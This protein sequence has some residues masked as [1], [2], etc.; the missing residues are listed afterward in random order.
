MEKLKIKEAVI[1]EGKYDKNKVSQI[2][3]TVII[4][5]DGFSFFN[6]IDK[7]NFIKKI[8]EE[9]GII[10]LTDS[11]SAGFLIR[12]K[13]KSIISE[14]KIKNAYIPQIEG[15]EKRKSSASK[16]GLLGVEGMDV[17]IILNALKCATEAQNDNLRDL[18]A[19]DLY[20]LGL[21]GKPGSKARRAQFLKDFN[22]PSF[23][24]NNDLLKY[25][26][27]NSEVKQC[28]FKNLERC[29]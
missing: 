10:I 24:N 6:S 17:S 2:V 26:N 18:T 16:E 25:I 28:L 5:T 15:K 19:A 1:V 29:I 7:I 8:A 23:I 27:S 13:L 3:D 20:E 4:Q 9:R 21:T 22:I 12:N 11:D 14:D